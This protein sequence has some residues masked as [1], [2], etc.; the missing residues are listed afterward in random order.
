MLRR[1]HRED[2]AGRMER[3]AATRQCWCVCVCVC[4]GD[5]K[6]TRWYATSVWLAENVVVEGK[7]SPSRRRA[8]HPSG[9]RYR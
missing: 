5:A 3:R 8:D 6:P 9:T 4:R 2:R 7:E 1:V